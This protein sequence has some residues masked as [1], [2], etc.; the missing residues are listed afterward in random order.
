[1]AVVDKECK[2]LTKRMESLWYLASNINEIDASA[3]LMEPLIEYYPVSNI[4]D[5]FQLI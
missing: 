1:M 2:K 4:I 5:N 3:R